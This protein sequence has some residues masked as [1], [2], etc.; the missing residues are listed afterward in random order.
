MG[1]AAPEAIE[2]SM[3][4]CDRCFAKIEIDAEFCTECGARINGNGSAVVD[5]AV[6]P[7][8]ARANLLRMRGHHADAEK[9][10]L[11]V[12]KQFPY[13]STAHILLGDIHA[14]KGHPRE[15][16]DWYE[17]AVDLEP[18]NASLKA[19][20]D[21]LKRER[22]KEEAVAATAELAVPTSNART[23]LI[24][25]AIVI[26][27]VAVV[28]GAYLVGQR[29]ANTDVNLDDLIR[30]VSIGESAPPQP[31]PNGTAIPEQPEA[32]SNETERPIM[33]PP[34][35]MTAQE[36]GIKRDASARLGP[37]GNQ[38]LHIEFDS[39]DRSAR[40][41]AS[42]SGEALLVDAAK[43]GAAIL[44]VTEN[45]TRVHVRIIDTS[46][47]DAK[48]IGTVSRESLTAA[49][50]IQEGSPEWASAVIFDVV[51]R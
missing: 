43:I 2:Q 44:F 26:L 10:C 17:L 8:L 21:R 19:K 20:R 7:Q 40:A 28:I 29:R 36:L 14:D 5:A 35:A 33:S 39:R 16:L 13:N 41:T 31:Q 49:Q 50:T 34:I 38:L 32:P 30:P 24:S 46:S 15:A 4:I 25:G 22:E 45:A 9:L 3:K 18:E 37:L 12:L 6:Y 47:G 23:V 51:Q 1:S 11:T 27:L 42:A 48:L